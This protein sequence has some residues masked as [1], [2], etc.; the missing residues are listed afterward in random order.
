MKA[1][2]GQRV[3]CGIV[4]SLLQ[5]L[6]GCLGE[7]ARAD[8]GPEEGSGPPQRIV[9]LVPAVTEMLLELGAQGRLVART[10]SDPYPA[11]AGLPSVGDP[12]R[13]SLEVLV[14][15][16]PD[17]VIAWSGLDL[18]ALERA[19]AGEGRVR[20]IS[21]N[22][23]A[24]I[25]PAITDVGRW[26]GEDEAADE[27]KRRVITSLR[28]ADRRGTDV[29]GP[30]VLWVVSSEPTVVAGPRTFIGDIIDLVG[31][32]NVAGSAR[33]SWPQLGREALLSLDPD[34]LVWSEG[35]GMFG[36]EQLR[37]RMPWSRLSS[38]KS[39]RVITVEGARFYVP[40]PRI[41]SAALDL[42]RSLAEL[43]RQ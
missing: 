13:P 15:S 22:R 29:E 25:G 34:V 33:T 23:L 43:D 24:D 20:S 28:V 27:L 26:I 11:L 7:G 35:A 39:D 4:L 14:A 2:A 18:S 1:I 21:I 38:V 42:A 10:G 5:A 12:L 32:R 37:Q 36:Q 40:G 9:S 19:M 8:R 6:V 41:A 16:D 3:R 30:S 31:G 17:L